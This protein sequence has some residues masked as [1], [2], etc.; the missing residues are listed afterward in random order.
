VLSVIAYHLAPHRI[1]GGFVGV[2][3]FFV[4]SGFLI[5]SIIY[6][7]LESG[8]FSIVGFYVRRIR[9]IYPALFV[10]L[11]FVCL[12]GWFILLPSDFVL[13]GKQIVGGSAFVA[14]FVL[15]QQ[16]GYFA[17]EATQQPLLH[18]WSLGVEEQ[19]YLVF[20]LICLIFFR[21]KSRWSLPAAFLAIALASMAVNVAFVTKYS[22]AT[23]FLPF[24]RLW[25]LFLGAGLSLVR[26]RNHKIEWAG[27]RSSL[28]RSCIGFLGIGMLSG[29][30]LGINQSDRFPGWWALLPTIGTTLLIAAGPSSWLNRSVLSRDPVV[31]VGLISYPL[32]LWHWP[33][34]SFIETVNRNGML[35]L[36]KLLRYS[37][38]LIASSALAYLTYRFIELPIRQVKQRER[39]QRGA[40]R[41]LGCTAMTGVFGLLVVATSGFPARLP[42]AVVALDHD[43]RA[44]EAEVMRTGA[45]FL[46]PDQS[47][48]SFSDNC[49]DP[50]LWHAAQPLVFLWGDSHAADLLPGFRALQTRTGIRLAQ[51]TASSCEPILERWVPW[52]PVC[53]SI[54]DAIIGRIRIVKPDVVVMSADWTMWDINHDPA[55]D[56]KL[57]KT[58]ELVRAT[59]VHRVVLVGSAPFWSDRVPA[60]LVRE[61]RR[62]SSGSVPHRLS[63]SYLTD[64]D[65]TLLRAT[66]E[67][68]GAVFFSIFDKLCDQSS[69]MVTTG[70]QWSDL[71]TYDS[72][73]FTEHGSTIA[74]ELLWPIIIPPQ[75]GFEFPKIGNGPGFRKLDRTPVTQVAPCR[76]ERLPCAPS[77]R[78]THGRGG[79]VRYRSPCR[80]LGGH[81]FSG[82]ALRTAVESTG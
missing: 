34:L 18:L 57:Q 14:N 19:F 7:E 80:V 64:H 6:Q 60:L 63:R 72:A 37:I 16:S 44:R 66:A 61:L 59:G 33:I 3:I 20:P 75:R 38:V 82:L 26:M 79:R 58:I 40:L 50:A 70:D 30:I 25:E 77:L 52:R 23:F 62:S 55:V 48:S 43:F 11:V 29:A 45:C 76:K 68:G 13:L 28:C 67:K 81:G 42:A 4:I 24:S 69:C 10:V 71:L 12:V 65:D 31:L 35:N 32:Y 47:A 2:D 36:P 5:S 41:L 78:G 22:D 56:D 15:W 39:R 9:R 1:R 8:S 27:P 21:A 74:A 54:N 46:R 51:Y 49:L 17:Q 53:R 73:H